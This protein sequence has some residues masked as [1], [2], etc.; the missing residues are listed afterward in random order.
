ML[1]NLVL[2]IVQTNTYKM[3][4][5]ILYRKSTINLMLFVAFCFG[6]SLQSIASEEKEIQ[7]DGSKGVTVVYYVTT[8]GSDT[9]NGLSWAT[10]FESV[11]HAINTAEADTADAEV[12]VAQGTYYPT[13]CLTDADGLQTANEYKSFIMYAGVDV[14]GGFFG[15]E[16]TRDIGVTGGRQLG[17]SGEIWDF[18]YPTILDGSNSSSYHVVWFGSNGFSSF[19]YAGIESVQIPNTLNSECLMHGFTIK[20]GFANINIRIENTT[21]SKRKYI[22]TAGG[23][24][25]ITGN[26]ILSC[27]IV[28]NNMAKIG[29]AGIAMFNGAKVINC[30]VTENEAIGAHY[31][32]SLLTP[33]LFVSFDYWRADGA[34]I[35]AGGS[36]TSCC[37]IDGC[38]IHNNLARANDNYPNAASSTNN[39][40]N[41]G[42]GVYLVFTRL[43]NSLVSSNNILKNPSPYD[44]NSSASCGGGIYLYKNAVVDSCE[45]TDNGFLTDSQNGAGIFIADYG[46]EATSYNDLV[47]TNSYVHS[48]RA[49]VAIAS[50][51]QYSSISNNIVA[52]NAG[53]GIYGYGNST[54][55]RTINCLIYNN[56]STGWGQ[57]TNTGNSLNSIINSTVVNNGIGISVGNSNNQ[58][59][60]NCIVWGNNSNPSTINSNATVF[61]SAFSFT[62]PPGSGNFQIDSDNSLGPKFENPTSTYGIN[63]AGWDTAS[64]KLENFSPCID[65]GDET[66]ITPLTAIDLEANPRLI[67]CNVDLG[68]YES[69]YGGPELDFALNSS[70]ID[71]SII[72]ICNK[73]IL[74]FSIDSIVSGTPPFIVSWVFNNNPYH[75]LSGTDVLIDSAGQILFDTILDGG[76][77]QIKITSIKDTND[78]VSSLTGLQ[79]D[80]FVSPIFVVI[81]NNDILTAIAN[82]ATYQWVDCDNFYSPI[83]GETDS[84]FVALSN[85]NY[86]VIV[87]QN[88]CIDTSACFFVSN[89]KIQ[90]NQKAQLKIYP[91]PNQGKFFFE[92][93]ISSDIFIFNTSGSLVYQGYFEKGTHSLDL[94]YLSSG[95]YFI[96]VRSQDETHRLTMVIQ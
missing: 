63:V 28:K 14:Y 2:I 67:G 35:M 83:P 65:M 81:Q 92:S 88:S 24:V 31:Y 64:W 21:N 46:E 20:N 89:A 93:N 26:G 44:G 25:A 70:L 6:I 9:A 80:I 41:N 94:S 69:P 11:Q 71:N 49:G 51:A 58:V 8:T 73:D 61:N 59:V 60:S 96:N 87:E 5:F 29:G 4:H 10:A 74:E 53:A 37:I 33:P 66:Q 50:D 36:D 18:A 76:Q 17:T 79:A 39:K 55:A 1:F 23:G 95:V 75:P 42:G 40:T 77:Y 72:N 13:E 15:N 19:T 48:N 54:R 30:F 57:S 27:C 12:W 85:G 56:Q 84:I 16:T 52:N 45:I 62:P 47:V 32:N 7:K 43:S 86:A 78:C 22:H 3:K 90:D 38:K 34:G 82:S 68:A 91:N